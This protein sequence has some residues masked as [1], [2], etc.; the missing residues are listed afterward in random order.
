MKLG[1]GLRDRLVGDAHDGLRTG[2]RLGLRDAHDGLLVPTVE[3][4]FRFVWLLVFIFRR[5]EMGGAWTH[6]ETF[7]SSYFISPPKKELFSRHGRLAEQKGGGRSLANEGTSPAATRHVRD[8]P[9][10]FKYPRVYDTE[11]M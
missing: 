5:K 6:N 2:L 8:T 7:F 10:P 9:F 4:V 11:G 3:Y 1:E